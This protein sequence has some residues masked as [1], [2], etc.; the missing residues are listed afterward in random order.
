KRSSNRL[1]RCRDDRP[2]P[3]GDRLHA[4]RRRLAAHAGTHHADAVGRVLSRQHR[5]AGRRSRVL[6]HQ[7][8]RTAERRRDTQEAIEEETR[9]A[10][11][12]I[13]ALMR[14]EVSKTVATLSDEEWERVKRDEDQRRKEQKP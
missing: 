14:A 9:K 8:A 2:R 1:S 13:L 7:Q 5:A 3:R 11:A 4:A 12:K 6:P 10:K